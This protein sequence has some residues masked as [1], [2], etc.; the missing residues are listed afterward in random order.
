MVERLLS[1]LRA[2]SPVIS[3]IVK[4]SGA[5]GASIGVLHQGEVI[6]TEGF[7]FYDEKH[8]TPDENTIYY[9]ASLSKTFTASAVA[10]L[11]EWGKLEWTTPISSVL[12]EFQH[13]DSN[14]QANATIVDFLAHRSGLAPKNNIW[15]AEFGQSTMGKNA[16]IPM[17]NSLEKLFELREGFQYNNWGYAVADEVITA[18]SGEFSWGTALHKYIFEPLE[19]TRTITSSRSDLDNRAEPYQSFSSL[20]PHHLKPRPQFEDGHIMQGAVGVQSCVSDLLK[21]YKAI[22]SAWE[23]QEQQKTTSSPGNPL[24]Q[25]STLLQSHAKM[26][27]LP[28]GNEN[29]YA[30]AWARTEFPAPMGSIGLNPTY[31]PEMPIVGKNLSKPRLG[32]WHQGSNMC[33]L[34]FVTLLPD[35]RTAVVVLSNG[36]ANNDV[37]DWIGQLLLQTIFEDPE[38]VDYLELAKLSAARSNARWPKITEDLEKERTPG[39]TH[40]PLTSYV[41]KFY[42]KIGTFGLEFRLQES[43]LQFCFQ[44]N[45]AYWYSMEHY[46]NDIFTWVLTR[47]QN[48]ERGRFPVT[49][50]AFYKIRFQKG[51]DGSVDSLIWEHDGAWD[52]GEVFSRRETGSEKL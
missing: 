5:P 42:N 31:I 13:W 32:F 52:A 4:S 38:P 21:Y 3:E 46:E 35:T 25:V 2:L 48:V 40:L 15:N 1:R 8:E 17:V 24:F 43:G 50:R 11:V 9:L 20:E 14:V 16:A 33:T 34:N 27:R 51:D 12:P 18:L 37:S 6:H 22:L 45:H 23:D 28:S 36:L 44:E 26:F 30:L 49:W 7:G 41:G 10:T 19:M 29:S 39:T 47:D